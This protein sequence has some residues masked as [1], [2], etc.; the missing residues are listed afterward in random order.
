MLEMKTVE[1]KEKLKE[2]AL[3]EIEEIKKLYKKEDPCIADIGAN[4]G[5]YTE[6][7][8]EVFKDS[9]IHSYEPHP[10]NL[11]F[12]KNIKLE[13]VFIH[14]YGLFDEDCKLKIGLPAG[15]E[16]N[17]GLFSIRY[18]ENAIE[19]TLKDC[20]K[21][22]IRPN[23]VKIDVEGSEEKILKCC[24]FFENCSIILIEMLSEDNFKKDQE[25]KDIL[26]NLGFV[27]FKKVSKN[28]Q[29]WVRK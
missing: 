9:E 17:N 20:N 8:K 5:Y 16:E 23:I 13:N 19:V 18:T 14:D 1:L 11:S 21:E 28:N 15:R 7:F 24:N 26:S 22:S 25:L 6:C 2:K 3:K 10:Y 12:L 4:I 27:F 29:I